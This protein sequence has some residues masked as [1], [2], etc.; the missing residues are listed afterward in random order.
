M[1]LSNKQK[2]LREKSRARAAKWGN[3]LEASR[4]MKLEERARE[5]RER[6]IALEKIDKEEAEFREAERK[7]VLERAEHILFQQNE[8]VKAMNCVLHQADIIDEWKEQTRIK[9]II[10]ERKKRQ[11]QRFF[12]ACQE[13]NRKYDE[14]E[15]A[16]KLKSLENRK[17][18]AMVQ[19]KQL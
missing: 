9:N 1:G 13:R 7:K 18:V 17:H 16:K 8:R 5:L 6:E 2:E 3:T 19:K 12:E 15:H 4:R 10:E 14:A 11:D